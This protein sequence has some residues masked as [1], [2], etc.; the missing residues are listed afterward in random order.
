[1]QHRTTTANHLFRGVFI[2]ARHTSGPAA[3][4]ALTAV[5]FLLSNSARA[6][7]LSVRIADGNDDA[8]EHIN[9]GNSIDIGSSDLE[10]GAEGGGND[11]QLIGMRFLDID[12]P[13]GA[14]INSAN[15]QFT[16]DETDNEVQTSPIEIFG[17]LGD[18][19]R[20]SGTGRDISNR[21]RTGGSVEWADIPPW[22]TVGEA[23][24]DQQTPD[25]GTI[26]QAI[27]NQ[28]TWEPNNALVI[29]MSGQE[30]FERTAE[31][32][33]GTPEAAALLTIDFDPNSFF[34]FGDY[35]DD[36][37][38][39]LADYDILKANFSTGTTF[40][41][42]DGTLDGKVDLD[43]FV[44]FV[45]AFNAGAGNAA[46]VPEPSSWLLAGCGVALLW[47]QRRRQRG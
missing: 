47:L 22:D 12:I 28:I 34:T 24:P 21:K 27:V 29:M 41:E 8:E 19:L 36:G 32:F 9:E 6:D 5:A 37:T 14:R 16:V 15:I 11:A 13:R 17:E 46:A 44:D 1:M 26:I 25:I 7:V 30:Q 3:L 45:Q 20:F 39:D 35:N 2:Q 33:N 23:G 38:V 4:V 42:G 40:A 18:A 43:D 31:S 10:I